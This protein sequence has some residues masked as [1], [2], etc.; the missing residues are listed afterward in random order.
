MG[1]KLRKSSKDCIAKLIVIPY[2]TMVFLQWNRVPME[3]RSF[4]Q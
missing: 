4:D 2:P 1:H 3:E